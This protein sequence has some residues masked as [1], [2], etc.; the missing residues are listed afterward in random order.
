MYGHRG[1]R[2]GSNALRTRNRRGLGLSDHLGRCLLHDGAPGPARITGLDGPRFG[3]AFPCPHTVGSMTTNWNDMAPLARACT[4]MSLAV[5]GIALAVLVWSMLPTGFKDWVYGR[6]LPVDMDAVTPDGHTWLKTAVD[7]QSPAARTR[8]AL[9]TASLTMRK[10]RTVPD[11]AMTLAPMPRVD[12]TAG[13]STQTDVVTVTAEMILDHTVFD[14]DLHAIVGADGLV[15]VGVDRKTDASV[16]WAGR[17]HHKM[18][19]VA[20]GRDPWARVLPTD[21][22]PPSTTLAVLVQED[23]PRHGSQ[24]IFGRDGATA[25]WSPLAE[26]AAVGAGSL[27]ATGVPTMGLDDF[28]E[29]DIDNA[30]W[31]LAWRELDNALENDRQKANRVA[32]ETFGPMMV[33]LIRYHDINDARIHARCVAETEEM[34]ASV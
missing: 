5:I 7:M 3:G 13:R 31:E 15:A 17:T 6:S 11:V 22:T 12:R 25:D 18:P 26:L 20:V 21:E 1:Q 28:T 34:F 27:A 33:N 8:R 4:G 32:I 30:R 2:G 9:D 29:E 23:T 16:E 24:D 14:T 19:A 10:A